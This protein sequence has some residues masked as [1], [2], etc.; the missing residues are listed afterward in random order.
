[1]EATMPSQRANPTED[2][3][4]RRFV[5]VGTVPVVAP[6]TGAAC[7]PMLAWTRDLPIGV[8]LV[9]RRLREDLLLRA[10]IAHQGATDWHER[11]HH[12]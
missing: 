12:V 6:G 3:G 5:N 7:G 9:A 10:G 1:M 11:R 2:D 8:P 4:F